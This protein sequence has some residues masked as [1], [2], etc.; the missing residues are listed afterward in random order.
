M[1]YFGIIIL[2]LL[3]LFML[4]VNTIIIE[5]SPQLPSGS[6][7]ASINT[8]DDM[9]DFLEQMYLICLLNPND[10]TANIQNTNSY[11]ISILGSYLWPLLGPFTNW[12]LDELSPL[13]GSPT[14]PTSVLQGS[15]EQSSGKTPPVPIIASDKDYVL[16]LQLSI[17]G[18]MIMPFSTYPST[19]PNKSVTVWR[20]TSTG[21]TTTVDDKSKK[22]GDPSWGH[23]VNISNTYLSQITM[24][25]AH[26]HG[27]TTSAIRSYPGDSIYTELY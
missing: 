11:K 7:Q 26:F 24:I 18:S 15:A 20:N 21:T 14:N 2:C 22:G 12:S 27:Q 25:L 10:Q 17:L 9:R 1:K 8:I 23:A 4:Y 16:F 5:G 13:F 6:N 3:M 19:D